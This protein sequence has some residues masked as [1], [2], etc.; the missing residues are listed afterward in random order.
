MIMR[1]V[2]AVLKRTPEHL[3][4]E[5]V[6]IDDCSD[7]GWKKSIEIISVFIKT[8]LSE[9]LKKPLEDFIRPY[10]KIKLVRSPIRVGLIK[11][12]MIGCVNAEGP[13][14]VCVLIITFL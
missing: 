3:L 13:A 7:R 12:R 8:Y 10:P 4:G 6:L 1:S 11:A 9:Q 5:I 14:L 2:F